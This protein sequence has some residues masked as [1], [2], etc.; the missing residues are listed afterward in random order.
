MIRI[1]TTSAHIHT[2]GETIDF[3]KLDKMIQISEK[4]D[5]PNTYNGFSHNISFFIPGRTSSD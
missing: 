1:H 2:Y 3:G 5:R 4:L